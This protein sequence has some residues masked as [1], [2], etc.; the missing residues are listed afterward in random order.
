MTTAPRFCLRPFQRRPLVSYLLNRPAS[1]ELLHHIV[2]ATVQVL[3]A[4]KD[5]F[6]PAITSATA[7]RASV[8]AHVPLGRLGWKADIPS[9]L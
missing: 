4:V 6:K 8:S 3:Q 2:V 1:N 5:G 7:A 9:L